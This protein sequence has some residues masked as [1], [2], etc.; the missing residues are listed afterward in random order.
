MDN[1]IT[2]KVWI[3][4]IDRNEIKLVNLITMKVRII[5]IDNNLKRNW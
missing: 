2:M 1:F 4:W 3:I 5:S